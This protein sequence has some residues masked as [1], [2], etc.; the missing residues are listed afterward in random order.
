MPITRINEFQAKEDTGDQL[1]ELLQAVKSVIKADSNCQDCQMFRNQDDPTKM[2]VIET[3]SSVA[4]HQAS[5]QKIPAHL[6]E[7][8]MRLVAQRPTGGYYRE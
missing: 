6:F 8:A 7:K 3:W 1:W 2:V 4:A 5:T